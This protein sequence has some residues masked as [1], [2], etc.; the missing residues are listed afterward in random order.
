MVQGY[1][2]VKRDGKAVY[3]NGKKLSPGKWLT[4]KKADVA[5]RGFHFSDNPL[6][7]LGFYG[8]PKEDTWYSILADGDID[9]DE[10]GRMTCTKI[11]LVEELSL[12]KMVFAA[13]D[14]IIENPY[15]EG[16]Y[17]ASMVNRD[18]CG[19]RSHFAIVRGKT[20]RARGGAGMLIGMLEEEI[21]SK[22]I[23]SATLFRVDGENYFPGVWYALRDGKVEEISEKEDDG[24]NSMAGEDN[25]GEEYDRC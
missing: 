4:E 2:G 18:L 20:P 3:G 24:N 23:K 25:E 5:R 8:N 9:E 21:D 1:K 13:M 10:D 14:Y 16:D 12:P 6:V 15:N 11:M 7:A 19:Y 22:E 17:G